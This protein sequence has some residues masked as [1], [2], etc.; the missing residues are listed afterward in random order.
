MYAGTTIDPIFERLDFRGLRRELGAAT[1][2]EPQRKQ[3]LAVLGILELPGDHGSELKTLLEVP[4]A[5]Q[6]VGP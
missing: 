4:D 2:P 6:T 5:E 1:V 3:M